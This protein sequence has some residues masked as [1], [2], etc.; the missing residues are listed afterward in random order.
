MVDY[1]VHTYPL[2]C[3]LCHDSRASLQ[4]TDIQYDSDQVQVITADGSKHTA[5]KVR[6]QHCSRMSAFLTV[7]RIYLGLKHMLGKRSII[8]SY[9][10]FIIY[11]F[12]HLSLFIYFIYL[13]IHLCIFI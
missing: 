7:E 8:F 5:T 13:V 3:L 11:L 12:I 4:V 6:I 1:E 9:F 10:I 2:A